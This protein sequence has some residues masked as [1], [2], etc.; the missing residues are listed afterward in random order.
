MLT[1]YIDISNN[2][3]TINL[4]NYD[5]ENLKCLGLKPLYATLYPRYI[6]SHRNI[7]YG[8]FTHYECDLTND[9]VNALNILN[10]DNCGHFRNIYPLNSNGIVE[11]YIYQNQIYFPNI[12]SLEAYKKYGHIRKEL[13]KKYNLY[14]EYYEPTKDEIFDEYYAKIAKI[15]EMNCVYYE[16]SSKENFEIFY[17]YLKYRLKPYTNPNN[18][19]GHDVRRW[20]NTNANIFKILDYPL[21]MKGVY[22]IAAM[23]IINSILETKLDI[24]TTLYNLAKETNDTKKLVHDLLVAFNV[25]HSF[26]GI[27]TSNPFELEQQHEAMTKREYWIDMFRKASSDLLVQLIGLDKIETQRRKTITTTK[28]NIYEEFFN[29]NLLGYDIIQLPKL[30]C[31]NGYLRWINPKDFVTTSIN[32]ECENE[33][34]L[35]KKSEP[36]DQWYKFLRN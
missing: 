3:K 4:V 9:V 31:D 20:I 26:D 21:D 14:K 12:E 32:R 10:S 6:N 33:L 30:I 18:L 2:S 23:D 29:L 8:G 16:L 35:I 15:N 1:N 19:T 34:K 5:D 13:E 36:R 17:S 28:P 22:N 11:F 7:Y 25:Y 24:Y 27:K